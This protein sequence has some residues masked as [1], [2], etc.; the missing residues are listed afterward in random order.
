MKTNRRYKRLLIIIPCLLL[1]ALG[2][3]AH[4]VLPAS[5]DPRADSLPAAVE[6][7]KS[8]LLS[9]NP[10]VNP[11]ST[12]PMLQ[13]TTKEADFQN[14]T[15]ADSSI[16]TDSKDS[17]S[18]KPAKEIDSKDTSSL[19]AEEAVSSKF[20]AEADAHEDIT[21]MALGDNLFHMGVIN[22]GKQEDGSLNYD[23]L[24][25]NLTPLLEASQIRMINQETILGGN[26]LGFSGYPYFN[27]PTEVGESLI[28]SGFNVVLHASNH[29]GDQKI[30]GLLN[31]A[32]F[33]EDYPEVLCVGIHERSTLDKKS[34]Q[35]ISYIN[36]EDYTFAVLNYT[37]GPNME[38]LP[39][40][41]Q[42]HLDLLCDWNSHS[43]AID[44][45][46]LNP[47]VVE[48]IKMAK[49][50]ADIVIVCPH[51]GTEY[52]TSPSTVQK[53]FAL[54]MTE[55]GADLII[56]TH[57]HV[58]QPV[59][60]ITAEN[61]NRALC[62][63]SLGNYVSTQKKPLCMLEAMAWVRFE[64]TDSGL[65]VKEDATGV[66]PLV[67]HYNSNPVQVENVYL[68]ENYTEDQC[69]HHGIKD[70]GEG[71]LRYADLQ[72][73]KDEILGD[74]VLSMEDAISP[75]TAANPEK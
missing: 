59:E 47:R 26:E 61:G 68:L 31:C 57:P 62:Y 44:F 35:R 55:A 14:I 10:Q 36:I 49:K 73:W 64:K 15:S 56:G 29:A 40:S 75:V 52:T 19:S 60:W 6:L 67:C 42:G 9:V 66:I 4:V 46:T 51:W 28:K 63:Y 13:D 16:G 5:S 22:A 72:K 50:M 38:V 18:A 53:K 69:N 21:L 71:P 54:E 74:F 2:I 41:L 45:T 17:S 12:A 24:Y 37:Y 34:W 1:L 27:S 7:P 39:S 32:D 70:Y 20:R 23:F 8:E 11:S 48:D 43:G 33:W 65:S 58:V 25:Q 30:Q 3:Y